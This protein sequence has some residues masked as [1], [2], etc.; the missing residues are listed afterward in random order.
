MAID[1]LGLPHTIMKSDVA[2][3]VEAV[4]IV[5]ARQ[6]VLDTI[7]RELAIL[8]AV[9][10]AADECAE[11]AALIA[12]ADIVGNGVVAE[13]DVEHVAMA[14]RHKDTDDASAEIGEA[15]FHTIVV[16]E[17]IEV[18]GHTE[19]FGLKIAAEQATLGRAF[20]FSTS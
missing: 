11:V 4:A 13:A 2:T 8:D 3:A 17:G 9:A 20:I 7:Q 6:L 1:R 12:I 14:V 19:M 15:Y 18:G 10:I 5:V 16:G